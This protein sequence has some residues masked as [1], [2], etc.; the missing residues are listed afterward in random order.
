MSPPPALPVVFS[1][2]RLYTVS[3][4]DRLKMRIRHNISHIGNAQ[5]QGA[6]F[7]NHKC[8]I[9]LLAGVE[10]LLITPATSKRQVLEITDAA[11]GT[12][13]AIELSYK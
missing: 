11:L 2:W 7:K 6:T 8:V 13:L 1:T 10:S 12:C 5:T 9:I 3:I 4:C